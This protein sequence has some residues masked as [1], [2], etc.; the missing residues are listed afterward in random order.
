MRDSNAGTDSPLSV[1]LV[2]VGEN[3]ATKKASDLGH[4]ALSKA[5]EAAG[6]SAVAKVAAK[7]AHKAVDTAQGKFHA[8]N[9]MDA[10]AG[11]GKGKNG[12]KKNGQKGEDVH[13]TA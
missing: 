4:S 9:G 3:A 13:F 10:P 11:K 7:E 2:A 1:G 5:E 6:D 8:A 12:K